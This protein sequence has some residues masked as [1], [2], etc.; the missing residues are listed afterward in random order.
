MEM[1]SFWRY[2][3]L[4]QLKLGQLVSYIT[5]FPLVTDSTVL[6]S[7]NMITSFFRRWLI[8]IL[9]KLIFWEARLVKYAVFSLSVPS[10]V[11]C[12]RNTLIG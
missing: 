4:V 9:T 2:I 6:C 12:T 1:I 10:L 7:V 11:E 8:Y 5:A 3:V